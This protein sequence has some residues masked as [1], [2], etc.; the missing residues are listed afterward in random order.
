[1]FCQK[2]EMDYQVHFDFLFHMAKQYIPKKEAAIKVGKSIKKYLKTV[3]PKY[4]VS[5]TPVI[6]RKVSDLL[7]GL[8]AGQSCFLNTIAGNTPHYVE[9]KR[10]GKILWKPAQVEKLSGWLDFP[11]FP[12]IL[13][14]YLSLLRKEMFPGKRVGDTAR[15]E[16]R[17]DKKRTVK[18]RVFR[19]RLMLH[20]GTDIQKPHARKME[21]LCHCRDGS[22]STREKPKTGK[23]YLIEGS[24]AW[25]KGRL[26]PCLL[27]LYS[28][29]EKDHLTE[30]EETKKNLKTLEGNRLLEGFLHVFDRGYDCTRFMAWC[31]REG[32]GFLIRANLNRSV[33][34][35]EEYDR[36]MG[37]TTAEKIRNQK[38]LEK[39]KGKDGKKKTTQKKREGMFYA[40]ESLIKR[41]SF[42]KH[43]HSRYSWFEVAWEKLYLKGEDFPKYADDVLPVTF[44][45][46]RITDKN[47]EGIDEDVYK[48]LC[49]DGN[50]GKKGEK[51][52][53]EI[54]LFTTEELRNIDD[55]VVL[56]LCYLLRW[57]IETFFRWTKQVLGLEKVRIQSF[58]KIRNLLLLLPIAAHYLYGKYR[59][60]EENEERGKTIISE[61]LFQKNS[62][63]RSEAVI[64]SEILFFHCREYCKGEGLTYNPDSFA[65]SVKE[66][67]KHDEAYYRI[68]LEYGFYDSG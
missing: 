5:F 64:V 47:V 27:S 1:M 52:E 32:V 49:S 36:R 28:T 34:R 8:I 23:G 21:K 53:R 43:T 11:F 57:K 51:G 37:M 68:T 31:L 58:K 50:K 4:S 67:M 63:K 65:R 3:K 38:Q 2:I 25:W 13:F 56:F 59:E 9:R 26:F 29:K 18:D 14:S 35:Q 40:I 61:T 41:M 24:T 66:L 7:F 16:R 20:D 17:K 33:I 60:F 54:Y 15:K 48:D 55:A 19:K 62:P 10:R 22:Q 42:R 6:W 46:A 45:I 44:I 39:E 30:K 12:R